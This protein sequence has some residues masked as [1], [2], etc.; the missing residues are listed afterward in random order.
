MRTLLQLVQELCRRHPPRR[1]EHWART[2]TLAVEAVR[3]RDRFL[4]A[5][6]C[7]YV[8]KPVSM[9]ELEDVLEALG[10]PVNPESTGDSG[11]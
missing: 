1:A 2:G 6:M 11:A 7:A 9:E 8:A 10:R 4:A 5:G 3:D